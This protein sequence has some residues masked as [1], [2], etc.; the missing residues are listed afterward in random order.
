[1]LLPSTNVMRNSM[2]SDSRTRS[3]RNCGTAAVRPKIDLHG[4]LC[5]AGLPFLDPCIRISFKAAQIRLEGDISASVSPQSRHTSAFFE[6]RTVAGKS[7]RVRENHANL[8]TVA[9]RKRNSTWWSRHCDGD[10][11]I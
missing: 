8:L 1:M 5:R 3:R 10:G 7:R 11:D 2:G 4:I 6:T 9:I